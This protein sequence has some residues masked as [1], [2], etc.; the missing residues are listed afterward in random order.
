[1]ADI[2]EELKN[3]TAALDTAKTA[4]G[5]AA[6]KIGQDTIGTRIHEAAEAALK[7]AKDDKDK[8]RITKALTPGI[9]EYT[10]QAA[11]H[12]SWMS[13]FATKIKEF[14]GLATPD[15]KA[16]GEKY[17]EGIK[18]VGDNK[19]KL[20]SF[21]GAVHY[22]VDELHLTEEAKK[23]LM[24]GEGKKNL[25][26]LGKLVNE[27]YLTKTFGFNKEGVLAATG[28][29]WKY[30]AAAAVAATA[31]GAVVSRPVD[32]QTGKKKWTFGR[33]LTT[34]LCVYAAARIGAG[35]YHGH[36]WGEMIKNPITFTKG[37]TRA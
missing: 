26:D 6:V 29:G 4:A 27:D 12:E 23:K 28:K 9:E 2:A 32:E 31:V 33:V 17:I 21:N 37:I 36:S 3:A 14:L 16:A 13:E 25:G 30:A 24:E 20:A 11:H 18:K 22:S 19:D 10:K 15:T 34:A 7:V 35:A 8:L 5:Q 1:M